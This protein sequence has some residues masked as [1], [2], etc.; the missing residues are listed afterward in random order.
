MARP[1]P[2]GVSRPA[3][4]LGRVC[5]GRDAPPLRLRRLRAADPV[6]PQ[7]GHDGGAI[8]GGDHPG[9]PL[10]EEGTPRGFHDVPLFIVSIL[11]SGTRC[12]RVQHM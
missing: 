6:L 8:R 9:V 10:S 11:Q 5:H 2:L 12:P 4:S 7:Q 1:P 3:A